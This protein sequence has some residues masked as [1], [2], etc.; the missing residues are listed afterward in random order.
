MI[1][2]FMWLKCSPP[3]PDNS[4]AQNVPKCNSST[5]FTRL[6]LQNIS[7]K[8]NPPGKQ[9]VHQNIRALQG[10]FMHDHT[11]ESEKILLMKLL[12]G[13]LDAE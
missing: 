13:D 1:K 11:C 10:L 3:Q 12:T 5:L 8:L 6:F 2:M 7:Q 4:F 9:H